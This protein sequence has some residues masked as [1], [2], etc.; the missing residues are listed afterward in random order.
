MVER[1]AEVDQVIF[2]KTGTLTE[3]AAVLLDM[4]MQVEGDQRARLM[5]LLAMVEEQSR[6]PI[7]RPFAGFARP[8]PTEAMPRI[9]SLAIVPGCG[10]DAEIRGPGDWGTGGLGDWGTGGPI[11]RLRIGRPEWLGH[12]GTEAEE[13]LLPQLRAVEG[14]RIDFEVNGELAG[15]ARV[16]ERLRDAV[17]E[18]LSGLRN[19]GLDVDVLTGD[20]AERTAALGLSADGTGL[21]PEDKRSHIVKARQAGHKVLMVGDGINDAPALAA[22]HVGVALASGTDLANR[23]AS[24]TLYHGDL[25]VLPWAIA[26]S[27]SAMRTVQRNLLQALLYNIVGVMLAACGVLHPVAAALLMLASSLMV[28]WSSVRIGS[29]P[30]LS[31]CVDSTCGSQSWFVVRALARESGQNGLKPALQPIDLDRWKAVGHGLALALQGFI[32]LLLL[33]LSTPVAVAVAIGFIVL[34]IMTAWSWYRRP[35]LS[36]GWDMAY[37]MLNFGNLGMLLGW[38]ADNHFTPLHDAGCCA[39]AEAVREGLFRPWMWIGMLAGTTWR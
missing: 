28:A 12:I 27:R 21:L 2:D 32:F 3:D 23:A 10:V 22:A 35:G 5:G 16:A 24:I 30:E 11:L 29:S 7:A 17:P 36:H 14:H 33:E 20:T 4:V 9:E 15:V 26:L 1:L 31:R 25:R 38:W 6:H 34:G 13:H 19:L 18:A 39:C 8:F 37:G